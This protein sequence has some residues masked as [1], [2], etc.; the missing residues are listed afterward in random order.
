LGKR[1]KGIDI[2]FNALKNIFHLLIRI[3]RRPLS[4]K[5]GRFFVEVLLRPILQDGKDI[6]LV[7]DNRLPRHS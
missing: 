5:R 7:P 3:D 1:I 4:G 2:F 6:L